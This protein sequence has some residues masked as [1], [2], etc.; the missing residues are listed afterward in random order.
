MHDIRTR[1]IPFEFPQDIEPYWKP[2]MPEWSALLN[3]LSLTMPY[4]EPFLIRTIREAAESIEEAE[5]HSEVRAF[6]EQ[7]AQHFS[8]HRK[9]NELI[10]SKGY[11]HLAELESEM[12][13]Y[14]RKLDAASLQK[15]MAYTSGFETM[16]IGLTRFLINRR[17]WLFKDA[18]PRVASLMLW[19]I[20]E[21]AEHKS[22]AVDVYRAVCPGYRAWVFGLFHGSFH[23]LSMA[24]RGATMMLV[25][26]GR[27]KFVNKLRLTGLVASFLMT[28]AP[29]LVR[30][31]LPGH[32]PDH[33]ED[34][35]WVAQWINEYDVKEGVPLLDTSHDDIPASFT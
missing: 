14:Y 25:R 28:W 4:L 33:I 18:D 34:P 10:K 27:F 3:G 22:V 30:S 29:V 8:Q 31:L 20:V 15:R 12:E 7:E 13:S 24:I 23:V 35:P 21:E 9:F 5:L 17:R 19:H 1:R 11:P 6:V 2:D 16:T 26:D 32:H